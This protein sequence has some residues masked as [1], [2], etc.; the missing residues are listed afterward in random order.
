MNKRWILV[1]ED[2]RLVAKH[3]EN[4][5]RSLGYEVAGVA[6]TGEDAIRIALETVPDLVLMDIMLRGDMDG[7][8]A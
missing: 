8:G 4:M 6:A 3:I 2:E 7:I 1:V 5:V